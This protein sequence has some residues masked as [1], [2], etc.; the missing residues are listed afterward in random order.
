MNGDVTVIIVTWNSREELPGCLGSIEAAA[1]HVRCDIIVVDNQ[2]T[3]GTR[4]YLETSHPGVRVIAN[5]ENRGFAA[6]NNQALRLVRT[7]YVLLLNPDTVLHEEAIDRLVGCLDAHPEAFAAGPQVYNRDG[8]LQ[9]TGVT[10]PSIG[11][12]LADA[13]FLDR[14]FP[15]SRVFGRHRSLFDDPETERVVDY[16]QGSCLL[17]RQAAIA[18][19][20]ILDE[21]YFMYFEET[22]WCYRMHRAGGTV[23]I[24]PAAGVVH[25]GGEPSVHYG[26]ARLVDY[27]R[28]LLVFFV[29]HRSGPEQLVLR[30]VVILRSCLR[31]VT[32]AGVLLFRPRERR[33]ALSGI[34]GYGRVMLMVL[35]ENVP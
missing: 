8:S 21:E 33:A 12:L 23:R 3:D 5:A 9:R 26:A 20:G 28:G 22:D 6:A 7:R 24:C 11:N 30:G 4:A 15:S 18:K 13:F 2:S 35:R 31:I 27:H 17:V 34:R 10:F 14:L 32:W 29:R 1:R 25:F 19:V 16:V